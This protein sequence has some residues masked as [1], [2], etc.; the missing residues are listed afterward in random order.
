V[1]DVTASK[2]LQQ[3]YLAQCDRD[4]E[5]N[6]GIEIGTLDNPGWQVRVNVSG[7]NLEGREFNRVKV[8]RS[9]ADWIQAWVDEKTWHAACGPLTL[10]TPLASSSHGWEATELH[11]GLGRKGVPVFRNVP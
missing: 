3:W 7:T 9:D 5:H 6:S 4:W 11:Q 1:T 2:Q 8:E 10:T